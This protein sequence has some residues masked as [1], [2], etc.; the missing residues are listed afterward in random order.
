VDTLIHSTTE[1]L[2]AVRAALPAGQ[3]EF[4]GQWTLK[5]RTAQLEP[6]LPRSGLA[7]VRCER[8]RPLR[9]QP[10]HPRR[11]SAGQS[12]GRGQ[13][14]G[15]DRAAWR[16]IGPVKL[17]TQFDIAEADGVARLRQ[18]DVHLAGD[19]PVLTVQATRAAAFNLKE[20]R[21]Q[22]GGDEAGEILKLKLYGL[23]LAW[24]RPFV[25]AV[26]ISGG[27]ITGELVVSAERDRL[28]ARAIEPLRI[29]A[30][31]VVQRGQLVLSK[32][33]LLLNY[34]TALVDKVLQLHVSE[35]QL[36]TPAGDLLSAQGTVSMPLFGPT[37][38]AIAA[39]IRPTCRPCLRRGCRRAMSG[40]RVTPMWAFRRASLKWSVSRRWWQTRQ[41]DPARR[42]GAAPVHS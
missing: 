14:V 8:R 30:L 41:A 33:D 13:P 5:S 23:P 16:A 18:L 24:V 17:Q 21:L 15:S 10:V 42:C 31:T 29:N 38:L 39:A 27:L 37:T 36:Q 28:A 6:F 2:L 40:C 19:Q 32:A 22:V 25:H 3:K 35:L 4:A 12:R 34:D 20:R 9:L 11:E 7:G 26:D 1:N